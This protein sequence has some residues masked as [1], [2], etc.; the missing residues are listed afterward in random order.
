MEPLMTQIALYRL[1]GRIYPED[2]GGSRG[3]AGDNAG[4]GCEVGGDSGDRTGSHHLLQAQLCLHLNSND[5]PAANTES[6]GLFL[7][8]ANLA[9]WTVDR[10][11]NL[12]HM[13]LNDGHRLPAQWT[14]DHVD[15]V[16]SESDRQA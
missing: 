10:G 8:G 11:V 2:R 12:V 6:L 7:Q 3:H 9:C 5:S 13:F 14:I 1:L 4:G 16:L 15:L